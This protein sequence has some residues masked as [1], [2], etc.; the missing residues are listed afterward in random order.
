ML[1][2]SLWLGS[3]LRGRVPADDVLALMASIAPDAPATLTVDDRSGRP[4]VDALARIRSA[5]CARLLLPRPGNVVGW[6]PTLA[7]LPAPSVLVT[8]GAT[9]GARLRHG[10]D[11]WRLDR[12]VGA[13]VLPLQASAIPPRRLPGA[14]AELLV[15]TT[16]RLLPLGLAR[17]PAGAPDEHWRRALAQLPPGLDP[18]LTATLHRVGDVLGALDVALADDGAAVTAGESRARRGALVPLRDGLHDL[19]VAAVGGAAVA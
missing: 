18:T 2:A 6:P 12:A 5:D 16:D 11:G 1:L 9:P 17:R 8:V 13:A 3:W 4:P 14:F 15:G 7:D 10:R 19:L